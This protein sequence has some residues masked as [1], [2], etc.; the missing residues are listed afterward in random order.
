MNTESANDRTL[1]TAG[2]IG[3]DEVGL[4][5]AYVT[6]QGIRFRRDNGR[7]SVPTAETMAK[8]ADEARAFALEVLRSV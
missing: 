4:R 5:A 8:W 7:E 3:G 1:A 6:Q 2:D